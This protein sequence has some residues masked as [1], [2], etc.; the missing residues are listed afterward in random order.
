GGI[1]L[2]CASDIAIAVTSARFGLPETGLGILPAQIAPFVVQRI[3]L[4]QAR[5]LGMCGARFDGKEAVRLGLAHYVESDGASLGARLSDVLT[6]I[7][8]FCL[9][10]TADTE[11]IM[12]A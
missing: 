10:A 7:L 6:Q 11:R 9:N 12:L 3:G 8:R 4:S 5:R 2:V 1:G